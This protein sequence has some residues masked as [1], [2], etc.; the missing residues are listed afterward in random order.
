[1]SAKLLTIDDR[2]V[3][4]LERRLKHAPERVWRAITD[5]AELAHWFP[6][7]VDVDLR[8]GGAIQFTFPGEDTTTT[9]RVVTADPPREFTFVWNDDTLRWLISPDG[10]GSLLEFTHTFGRGD[11]AIAKLAAGRNAAGWDVCLDALDARLAGR[12]FERPQRWHDR[13][14]SYVDEFGL[15]Y[16]EV[17]ADG[18]IRFRRDLVWKPVDEVRALLPGE[19]GWHV[20][21]DPLDGTRVEF[22]EAAEDDVPAQLTR[23]HEQLDKLFA[24]TFGVDL[25]DWTPDRV[26]ALKKHYG[27]RPTQG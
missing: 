10:D 24:A 2:P 1:M 11:P 19:P 20:V 22:A 8:D 9:G 17:P 27:Q 12:D 18:T 16:G 23:R 21:Q 4:R 5:P 25:P 14:A 15:G 7:R 6:A 26:E 3:L 13:M